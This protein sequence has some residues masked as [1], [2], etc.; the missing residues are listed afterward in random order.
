MPNSFL[1]GVLET[2]AVLAAFLAFGLGLAWA[3]AG[4]DY[5]TGEVSEVWLVDGYNVICAGALAV[6]ERERWWSQANRLQLLEL[7]EGLEPAGDEVWVVFD[8]DR[9]P[10][11]AHQGRAGVAFAAS[12]DDWLLAEVRRRVPEEQVCVVTADRKLADRA[13]HRGARLVTPRDF[14]RRCMGGPPRAGARS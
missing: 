2:A 10:E 4:G 9:T 8:G 6:P 14:V 3:W 1:R 12:A 13:R 11:A 7:A 5:A